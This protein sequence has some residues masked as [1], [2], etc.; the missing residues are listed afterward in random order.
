[1][2][3]RFQYQTGSSLAYSIERLSDG[4][5]WDFATTGVT[6]GTFTASPATLVQAL[7]ED[8]A[9]FLGR[10]KVTLA[11]P[12]LQFT[13]GGYCVT[14]HNANA[15]NQVV[16]E[17]SL[18]MH[19]ADDAPV[20]GTGGGTDPWLT[21]LPGTYLAGSAGA[22]LGGNLDAAVS[23]RLAT[24][25]YTVPDNTDIAALVASVGIGLHTELDAVKLQTD[26][27]TFTGSNLNTNMQVNSDKTGYQLAASGM[28]AIPVE[29]GVNARQALVPILAAAAGAI[30]G[31]GTGSIVIRGGNVNTTRITASTDSSGNRTSVTLSLPL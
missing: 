31:A 23:S 19:A 16:G 22:I 20:F 26:K 29:A 6:A 13:D 24:A 28:D 15:A 7:P 11:T 1:L 9:N 4:T 21:Q 30:S 27:L 25:G 14:I 8:S 5:F 18:V 2:R 12:A 17:L 3:I 10:Y